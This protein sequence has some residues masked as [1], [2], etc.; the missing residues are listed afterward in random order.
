[1]LLEEDVDAKVAWLEQQGVAVVAEPEDAL[2]ERCRV[3]LVRNS[4]GRVIERREPLGPSSSE[5]RGK[6]RCSRRPCC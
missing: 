3:A 6:K 2:D 1:L 4:R 5:P